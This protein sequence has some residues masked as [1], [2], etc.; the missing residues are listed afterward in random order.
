M[1]QVWIRYE[2]RVHGHPSETYFTFDKK[3]VMD[4][5][6]VEHYFENV[7][8]NKLPGGEHAGYEHEWKI[9]EHPPVKWLEKAQERAERAAVDAHEYQNFLTKELLKATNGKGITK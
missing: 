9:V 7:W 5:E 6:V 3:R 1:E 8:P 4:E 2:K